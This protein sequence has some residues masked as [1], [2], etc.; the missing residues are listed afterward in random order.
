[1]FFCWIFLFRSYVTQIAVLDSDGDYLCVY[2]F[3]IGRLS[4]EIET[5]I[6]WLNQWNFRRTPK[7]WHVPKNWPFWVWRPGTNR[8]VQHGRESAHKS[9]A[10]GA[11]SSL[12]WSLH[13]R[14]SARRRTRPSAGPE[15]SQL[16]QILPSLTVRQF[17]SGS[18]YFSW[19]ANIGGPQV[20]PVRQH[21]CRRQCFCNRQGFWMRQCFL[22]IFFDAYIFV[23]F[24]AFLFSMRQ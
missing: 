6:V 10:H 15:R 21:F 1:M 13:V 23:Y 4:A 20:F 2:C 18:A 24:S 14:D 16:L 12:I 8:P 7:I 11:P 9:R 5:A 17:F 3:L 19:C 22:C